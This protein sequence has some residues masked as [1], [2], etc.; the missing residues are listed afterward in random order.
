MILYV[1]TLGIK[2]YVCRTA[3]T[4][5]SEHELSEPCKNDLHLYNN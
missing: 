5:K 2:E 1:S 4:D 3:R